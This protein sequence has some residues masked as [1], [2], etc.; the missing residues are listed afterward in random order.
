MI[1]SITLPQSLYAIFNV[2]KNNQFAFRFVDP[3][4]HAT[5]YYVLVSGVVIITGFFLI[6]LIIL[7]YV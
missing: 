2:T 7:V 3:K 6:P 5:V 1:I 4:V